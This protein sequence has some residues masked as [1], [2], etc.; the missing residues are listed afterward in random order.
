[1]DVRSIDHVNL[2]IPEGG[3]SA[4]VAF[5]GDRLGFEIEGVARW[6]DGE[7]SFFDVRLAPDHVVHL[8]PTPAF[9]PP[10]GTNYDHL[11]VVVEDDIEAV[12]SQ[13]A[14][15]DVP[16][17]DELSSPLGATGEA[18]AVYVEDPFGYVVELK[19]SAE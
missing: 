11:A 2:R 10:T 4:A 16:L 14:A 5:Y 9:D 15:A 8:W 17:Y 1:M 13:L 7:K 12:K 19:T 6:R 18:P 3:H